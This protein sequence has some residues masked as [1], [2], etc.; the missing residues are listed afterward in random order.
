MRMKKYYMVIFLMLLGVVFRGLAPVAFAAAPPA[1]AGPGGLALIEIKITGNE[2]L[3]LQNNTGSAITDLSRYWL[4]DFN[5]VNPLAAGVSSSTQQLPSASLNSGQT[6]LLNSNGGS[7]CGAAVT[8]KLSISLTDSGGFLEVVQTNLVNGVLQQSA[9]DSVSWS[10]GANGTAGMIANVPSSSSD[11]AGAYYRYQSTSASPPYSWQPSDVDAT[12][13]CQLDVKVSSNLVPGPA[14]PGSQLLAGDPPP[15]IIMQA[16]E[17]SST[18]GPTMPVSDVGLAAPIINELLPNPAEPQS[19]DED[20]FI[21]L[22][23][24]NSRSFD[25][26][27]F[28][29]EVG[30]RTVHDYTFPDGTILPAHGF[31]AFY[32]IDTNLSLSNTGG[33]SRLLD[34]FA[35]VISQTDL[36]GTAKEGQAWALANGKWYWTLLPT[37]GALNIIHLPTTAKKSSSKIKLASASAAKA[38][39]T[40][41]SGQSGNSSTP[42]AVSS[43]GSLHAPILVGVGTLAILYALYEY[44][45]D[46][47]NRFYQFRRYREARRAAG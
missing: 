30:T 4:Y 34:P 26:S 16:G 45:H 38:N 21:E 40:G 13:A 47:A 2:F 11:P 37:P 31:V 36:Y 43:A 15:A 5:N 23:N 24:S 20:E 39:G 42:V 32:S 9:G 12:N 3:M 22:Y 18:G 1:I 25:L 35:N 17:D 46:L 14:N 33:Q 27:G 7:T 29:L 44:R 6:I 28:K 10:S 8:A 41:T 19:D